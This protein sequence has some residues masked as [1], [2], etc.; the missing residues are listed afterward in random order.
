MEKK[1]NRAL[2]L[3][4]TEWEM[5]KLAASKSEFRSINAYVTDTLVKRAKREAKK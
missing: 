5:V 2:F 1:R 4:D 3:T